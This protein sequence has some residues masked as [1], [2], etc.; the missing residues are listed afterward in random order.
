MQPSDRPRGSAVARVLSGI[1][2]M[3][4]GQGPGVILVV[5][6]LVYI[7]NPV[8]TARLRLEHPRTGILVA[9]SQRVASSPSARIAGGRRPS[10]RRIGRSKPAPTAD[11]GDVP[12]ILYPLYGRIVAL[13]ALSVDSE[14]TKPFAAIYA[15]VSLI[16]I[17]SAF[18]PVPDV[19]TPL[20]LVMP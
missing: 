15:M 12:A 4:R 16:S 9:S 19:C 1:V 3:Q 5:V 17:I 13:F 6:S 11:S 14:L 7:V 18:I 20:H 10:R 2:A 8:R